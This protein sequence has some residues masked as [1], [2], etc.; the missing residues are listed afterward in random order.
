M[1]KRRK[2]KLIDTG[3]ESAMRSNSGEKKKK[4]RNFQKEEGGGET[5]KEGEEGKK[6]TPLRA[7][8]N[9]FFFLKRKSFE[10][11]RLSTPGCRRPFLGPRAARGVG[12]GRPPFVSLRALLCDITHSTLF[13]VLVV[14]LLFFFFLFFGRAG[15]RA[16]LSLFASG[17]RKKPVL[18]ARF[19]SCADLP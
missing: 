6:K 17:S 18:S 4:E 3:V 15:R 2:K 11:A 12:K 7:A 10:S 9:F 1:R 5:R 16:R 19:P 8:H 14:V 13:G